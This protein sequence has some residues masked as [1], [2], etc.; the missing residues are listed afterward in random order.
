[1]PKAWAKHNLRRLIDSTVAG[2]AIANTLW[3]LAKKSLGEQNDSPF[4]QRIVDALPP[5][6]FSMPKFKIYDGRIDP[7]DHVRYYQQT[8]AY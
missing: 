3:D 4:T 6:K 2:K 7:T 5:K 8:M 1:M